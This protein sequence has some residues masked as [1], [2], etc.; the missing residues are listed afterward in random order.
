M[1][2]IFFKTKV[3]FAFNYIYLLVIKIYSI[4][5]FLLESC[6]YLNRLLNCPLGNG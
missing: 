5:I 4:T 2:H 3:D 1:I 6:K